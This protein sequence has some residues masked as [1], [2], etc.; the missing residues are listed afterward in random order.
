MQLNQE[1]KN[2]IYKITEFANV[3]QLKDIILD[4]FFANNVHVWMS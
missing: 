2:K 1:K 3:I 4:A